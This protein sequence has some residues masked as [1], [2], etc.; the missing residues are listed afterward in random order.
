MRIPSA[1]KAVILRSEGRC[2][3]PLCAGQPVDISDMGDPLLDVDHVDQLA[4]G[5]DD[6][7]AQMIALC[8]NCHRLKTYGRTRH[9]LIAVLRETARERHAAPFASTP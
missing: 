3:N 2:E 9:E 8:P 4:A 1:R 5:G 7:P 6:H